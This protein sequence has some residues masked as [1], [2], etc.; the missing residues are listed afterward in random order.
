MKQFVLPGFEKI[1]VGVC[2]INVRRVNLCAHGGLVESVQFFETSE[3]KHR[4]VFDDFDMAMD[5]LMDYDGEVYL[6]IPE[7]KEE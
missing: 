7:M 5:W 1:A 6:T 3:L 2:S 4:S